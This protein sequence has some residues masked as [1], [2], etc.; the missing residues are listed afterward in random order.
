MSIFD[1]WT[2]LADSDP[3]VPGD[4]IRIHLDFSC[5]AS[6]YPS[7]S[8]VSNT[9]AS[10]VNISDGSAVVSS[11]QG[12]SLSQITNLLSAGFEQEYVVTCNPAQPEQAGDLREAAQTALTQLQQSLL[13]PC[14]TYTV[15]II[16][17]FQAGS[18]IAGLSSA[19]A[20]SGVPQA[21]N[22]ASYAVIALVV[23]ALVFYF[24]LGRARA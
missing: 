11:I 19:A 2:T 9:I 17:K 1:G 13:I 21:I 22:T 14:S 23:L 10:M 16:E 4:Q 18:G 3:V 12:V 6:N 8:D 20:N 15:G 5:I 24:G 7:A